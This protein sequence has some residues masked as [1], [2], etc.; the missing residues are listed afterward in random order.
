MPFRTP[1]GISE[2]PLHVTLVELF[3]F[4]FF[5][6]QHPAAIF[7]HTNNNENAIVRYEWNFQRWQHHMDKSADSHHSHV[8]FE[9]ALPVTNVL[10]QSRHAF[11]IP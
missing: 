11:K 9:G 3:S 10:L 1:F 8:D 6:P 2:V 5:V 7:T 4:C